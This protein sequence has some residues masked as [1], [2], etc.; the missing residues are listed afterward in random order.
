MRRAGPPGVETGSRHSWYSTM[1]AACSVPKLPTG[2]RLGPECWA[3]R[4]RGRPDATRRC[5]DWFGSA[6]DL[7]GPSRRHRRITEIER[8]IRGQ[9]FSSAPALAA[10]QRCSR[11]DVFGD[12]RESSER[13]ARRSGFAVAD[14]QFLVERSRSQL[15]SSDP[16]CNCRRSWWLAVLHLCRTNVCIDERAASDH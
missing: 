4:H 10:D 9:P 1:A 13:S 2:L 11:R 8:R 14:P 16:Y 5:L 15:R 12:R 6:C 7:V 3:G